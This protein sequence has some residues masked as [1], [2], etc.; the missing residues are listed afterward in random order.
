MFESYQ[1]IGD[2]QGN[3]LNNDSK[4]FIAICTRED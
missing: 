2:F 3:E 1:I 4:E